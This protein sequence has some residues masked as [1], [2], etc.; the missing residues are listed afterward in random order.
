M[1]VRAFD[2]MKL[3]K[4]IV[5]ATMKN[6]NLSIKKKKGGF[7]VARQKQQKKLKS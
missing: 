3:L 7:P 5:K 6:Y 4:Y 2:V 1:C